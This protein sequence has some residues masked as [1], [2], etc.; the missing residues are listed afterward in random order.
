VNFGNLV[1]HLL[2]AVV[3]VNVKILKGTTLPQGFLSS[4]VWS[5]GEESTW[6]EVS[7]SL[8]FTESYIWKL[9]NNMSFVEFVE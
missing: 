5:A 4:K 2:Q 9:S 6:G 3:Y 7:G 1:F 8:L